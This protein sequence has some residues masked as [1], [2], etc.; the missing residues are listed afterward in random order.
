MGAP[1]KHEDYGKEVLRRA[2]QRHFNPKAK[3]YSFDSNA[4]MIKIDGV[5]KEKIAVEIES[6]QEKQ[7]CGALIH[8][9]FYPFKRKLLILIPVYNKEFA[10]C[11]CKIIIQKIRKRND[12]FE[13]VRLKGD[14]ENKKFNQDVKL[15][16]KAV[17]L[18][19][20]K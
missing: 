1:R 20:K 2:F 12:R 18:L 13:V 6:R 11:Q 19:E 5:I 7:V 16:K 3:V 15:I 17:R 10:E 9:A 8:L 4:G 14:G